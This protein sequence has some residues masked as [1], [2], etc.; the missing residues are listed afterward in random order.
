MYD[1]HADSLDIL[2]SFIKVCLSVCLPA[3]LSGYQSILHADLADRTV[4]L[5]VYL[6]ISLIC[7]TAKIFNCFSPVRPYVSRIY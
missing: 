5:L 2:L 4:P 1:S 7:M 6:T 3:S